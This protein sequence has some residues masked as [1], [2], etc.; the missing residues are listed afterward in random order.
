MRLIHYVF[1]VKLCKLICEAY[2]DATDN[3]GAIRGDTVKWLY[4]SRLRPHL[5]ILTASWVLN[6]H[7]STKRYNSVIKMLQPC[8]L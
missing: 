8:Y 1:P 6:E 7:N 2:P 3:R 5:H 4:I